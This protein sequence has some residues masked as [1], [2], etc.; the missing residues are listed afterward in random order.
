[1]KTIPPELL[2]PQPARPVRH[3]QERLT[4]APVRLVCLGLVAAILLSSWAYGWARPVPGP[5]LV[6]SVP[7][8]MSGGASPHLPWP[9]HGQA[10]LGVANTSAT[11]ATPNA[12]PQAIG[13]VAKVMT[14]LLVLQ[15]RPL[16]PGEQGPQIAVDAAAVRDYQTAQANGEATL[17][18]EAG[19]RLTES[20]A[21][22]GLLLLSANNAA[23]LLARWS[24]GSEAAFVQQMNA[25][26]KALGMRQ[27]TFADA[28]GVSSHTVSTTADLTVLGQAAMGNPALA[29]IV[30]QPSAN[31]PLAGTV[32]NAD[33]A[34]G[35]AGI[36]GLKAGSLPPPAG[37]TFLFAGREPVPGVGTVL[38]VG[39]VQGL[40]SLDDAYASVR[41]LLAAAPA[42]IRLQSAVHRGQTVGHIETASGTSSAVV[43]T[44]DLALPTYFG[45]R[46]TMKLN[47]AVPPLPVG[48]DTPVGNV[49]VASGPAAS[50]V[51]V[52]TA[53]RL[54]RPD[55]LWR[56][57]RTG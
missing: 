48:A 34:L 45:S 56:L 5:H 30:A 55:L 52:A 26:A 9:P 47:A 29:A 17:S 8:S 43:A 15:A 24:G 22:Q 31:L 57:W 7:H 19:E 25:R 12:Q 38:I 49:Q 33:T 40:A 28:S 41:A 13:S 39:A 23:S 50:S 51:P 42:G 44:R 3:E 10:A 18:V 11:L 14:A 2:P 36:V 53:Q 1:V 37:A 6:S 27:T 32:Q 21:L 4:S 35:T 16:R 54:D 46:I 20:Q